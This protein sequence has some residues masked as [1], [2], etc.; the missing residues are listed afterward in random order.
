M[1]SICGVKIL[2]C[3]ISREP[4]SMVMTALFK[5]GWMTILDTE[6]GENDEG[7]IEG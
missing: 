3:E 6:R 1:K 2:K 4:R 5:I 7:G